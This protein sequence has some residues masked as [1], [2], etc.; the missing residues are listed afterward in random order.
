ML[1]KFRTTTKLG[2]IAA[3][4]LA[5]L[6]VIACSSDA[7]TDTAADQPVSNTGSQTESSG[8][9]SLVS[10]DVVV[11]TPTVASEPPEVAVTPKEQPAPGSD[12]E[13]VLKG[14]ERQIRA[15]NNEDWQGFLDV[16]HPKFLHPPGVDKIQ[17]AF[18]EIGGDFGYF[19]PGF[20]VLGYNARDV[21]VTFPS[22]GVAVTDYAVYNYDDL[23]ASDT[24]RSWGE[25]EGLWYQDGGFMCS[26]DGVIKEEFFNK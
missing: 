17:F 9:S 1:F 8:E 22:E 12:E 4:L 10:E 18:E 20:T 24:S 13:G 25:H 14:L 16:C 15:L 6:L 5:M 26:L 21:V 19:L 3:V 23:V 7:D 11:P 2:W